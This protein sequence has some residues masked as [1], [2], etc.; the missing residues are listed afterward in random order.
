[1]IVKSKSRKRKTWHQ[2]LDYMEQGADERS[3]VITHN[4]RGKTTDEWE[5]EFLEAEANRTVKRTDS[6]TLYHEIISFH[7]DDYHVVTSETL[8]DIA[9]QYIN[10]R[11]ER[12]LVVAMSH[13]D[14]DHVHLHFCISGV[15]HSTG[16]SMRMS[17]TQFTA[18]KR[19]LQTYQQERYPELRKSIADH[20]RKA[21]QV[22]SEPEYLMKQR[23]GQPSNREVLTVQLKA[24][25]DQSRSLQAFGQA[26]Q[27]QG[28]EL[29][30][31]NGRPQGVK[32]DGVKYR[33]TSIGITK[34][35]LQRVNETP[36]R[37]EQLQRLRERGKEKEH[38]EPVRERLSREAK[39]PSGESTLQ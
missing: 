1:M 28:M 10:L 24:L 11:A 33:L 39:G 14:R 9:L 18:V 35:H 2:L 32:A 13:H 38:D 7:D 23:T 26:L 19:T 12:G 4:V 20:G 34:E 36:S 22:R 3:V 16:K 29:Y 30:M 17:Q 21:R 37:M 15:E 8:E 6:V 5:R 31:R 27:A 25:F